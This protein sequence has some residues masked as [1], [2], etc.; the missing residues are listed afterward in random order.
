MKNNLLILLLAF[1]I[2]LSAQNFEWAKSMGGVDLD[3]VSAMTIDQDNNVYLVGYYRGTA[4]FDPNTGSTLLTAV[5][6]WDV[7]VQKLDM[8]GNLLWV[9]SMGGPFNDVGYAVSVDNDGNV[10]TYGSFSTTADFDPGPGVTSITSEGDFDIFI[11]KLNSEGDFVWVK[12]MGGPEYDYGYAITID[13]ASNLY[14]TGGFKDTVDFD[15]G[16]GVT[17]LMAIGR[18]DIFVQK[19]DT[20]GNLIWVKSMGG[21]KNDLGHAITLDDLSNVYVAGEFSDTVDFD[22]NLGTSELAVVGDGDIFVLKL[23]TNGDLIWATGVGGKT[24]DEAQAITTD[25]LNSLYIT[26]TFEDTVDFDPNQGITQLIAAGKSDVFIQ[27]LDLDGNLEWAKGIGGPFKDL[28]TSITLD[29][30]GNLYTT[31]SFTGF[32]DFDPSPVVDLQLTATGNEDVFIQK[33]DTGGN[34][35]WA[36]GIGGG[37]LDRGD[38]T[39]IDKMGYLYTVGTFIQ[40]VDFDPD[41]GIANLTAE[42]L[43][44][45]F[46][47]KFKLEETVTIENALQLSVNI[48]PNP[49]RGILTVELP[50]SMLSAHVK[51]I[52][53]M[54][55]IAHQQSLSSTQ[56][57]IAIY[58][59]PCGLY[60]VVLSLHTGERLSSKLV[61][62]R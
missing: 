43:S 51:L 12:R 55:R 14:V 9:K 50:I 38:V 47:Q 39:A 41:P 15:P 25:G 36:K 17:E 11:Q 2:T 52:D 1:P 27:K 5:G 59:L 46:I 13:T 21:L 22:P 32:A 56:S 28:G 54:G 6:D 31:G 26:G 62:M 48:F 60:Q 20:A 58:H 34:L 7:F 33:M 18:S 40:T 35:I 10:Y 37:G 19:L 42:G 49:S 4:D 24:N 61:L 29:S 16:P 3:W 8:E 53:G 30:I 44:D 23:D 45:I 57:K